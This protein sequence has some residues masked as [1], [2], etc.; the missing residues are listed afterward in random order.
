MLQAAGQLIDTLV[1]R[2]YL[3]REPD[4][5]DGR[6]VTIALTKR[7]HAAAIVQAKAREKI[8]EELWASVGPDDLQRTRRTL[9]VLADIGR[10]Y[11]EGRP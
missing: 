5:D 7:G 1:V 3:E 2:G 11:S 8:D 6:R 4:G 9:A 10:Q